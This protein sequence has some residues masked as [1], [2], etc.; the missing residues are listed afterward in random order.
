MARW[1]NFKTIRKRGTSIVAI[2]QDISDI[3]TYDN[4][5]FGKSIFNNAYTKIF[6]RTEYLDLENLQRI[7]SNTENFYE[8][9]MRL[10]RGSALLEQRGM[11]LEL[12][13]AAFPQDKEI[14]EGG[15]IWKNY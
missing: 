9:V 14:I 11:L 12:D 13:I 1:K 15:K 4:G 5:N 3:V 10:K 6:F 2:T 8:K 7:V